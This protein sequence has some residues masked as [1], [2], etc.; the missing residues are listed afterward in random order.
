MSVDSPLVRFVPV[1][2]VAGA[3][4]RWG[5]GWLGRQ[6]SQAE[7]REWHSRKAGRRRDEWTAGRI[8]AKSALG[9]LAERSGHTALPPTAIEIE[10]SHESQDAGRP[11]STLPFSVSITHSRGLAAAAAATECVG[12]DVESRERSWP[13]VVLKL[14]DTVTSELPTEQR[15]AAAT[16]WTCVEA[17]LKHRGCGLRH[18]VS[19]IRLTNIADDG[20]FTWVEHGTSRY[21]RNRPDAR[22]GWVG[23]V[24]RHSLALVWDHTSRNTVR[25]DGASEVTP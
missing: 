13:R 2:H 10:P 15:P 24:G 3:A 23:Q 14:L 8:A 16:A 4:A 9:R 5:T 1:R 18:G 20:T 6:L 22:I 11:T 21:E 25:P 12:I 17:I 19:V 7:L